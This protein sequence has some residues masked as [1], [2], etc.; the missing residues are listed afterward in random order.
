MPKTF[1]GTEIVP[2]KNKQ[3]VKGENLKFQKVRESTG[4]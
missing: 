4:N 2:L 1:L 3:S